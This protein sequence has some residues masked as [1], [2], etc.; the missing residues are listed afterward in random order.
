MEKTGILPLSVKADGVTIFKLF[1]MTIE[2]TYVNINTVPKKLLKSEELK[3][4]NLGN[5]ES[6]PVPW[7]EWRAFPSRKENMHL[8]ENISQVLH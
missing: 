2:V 7:Y 3:I 6:L 5:F 4:H 8:K 1:E